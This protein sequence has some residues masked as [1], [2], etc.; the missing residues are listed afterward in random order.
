MP[1]PEPSP[2][3]RRRALRVILL[4]GLAILACEQI[5]RHGRDYVFADR[6]A[7]VEPG[8]IYR[9]AWQ[10]DW[11]MRRL[12]RDYHIKT[13]VALAHP[14]ESPMVAEE[15]ALSKELGVRWVHVPIVETRNP[16]DPSVSDRLEEAVRVIADPANQP[17]FF[18]CHHGI[19]RASMVQMAYRMLANGWTLDQAQSEIARNFGLRAVDKGPDYRHMAKFYTE[20]VL[21]KRQARQE[22]TTAA[23]R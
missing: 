4:A 14:P 8:K 7:T 10:K 21:P 19:N 17:V 22:A 20:R 11:P 5:W 12:V 13:I 23:L 15:K 6:F 16:G 18:H 1:T 2:I 3:R 9:G